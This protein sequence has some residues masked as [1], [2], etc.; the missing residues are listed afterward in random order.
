MD[1][2]SKIEAKG[3]ARGKAERKARIA[4]NMLQEDCA[5]S[6]VSKVT[7]LS[8]VQI[9]RL[10]GKE[11]VRRCVVRMLQKDFDHSLISKLTGF[12]ETEINHI[13]N[14]EKLRISFS[15]YGETRL[16]ETR[17]VLNIGAEIAGLDYISEIKDEKK[18]AEASGEAKGRAEG[19]TEAVVQML[20]EGCAYSLISEVTGLSKLEIK[21]RKNMEEAKKS[22]GHLVEEGRFDEEGL[23]EAIRI[24]SIGVEIAELDYLTLLDEKKEKAE[25]EGFAKGKAKAMHKITL[26]MLREGYDSSFI[27]KVTGL[28]KAKINRLKR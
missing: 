23:E 19:E 24:R 21:R 26:N 7:G 18:Q 1:H 11:E 4:A 15:R 28:S 17:R 27:S 20:Q 25:A 12:S 5:C 10:K 6:L 14:G 22:L 13:K 2:L 3:K 8:E 9:N 16:E